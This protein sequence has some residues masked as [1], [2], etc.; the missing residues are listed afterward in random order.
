MKKL[1]WGLTG[2]ILLGAAGLH[3][4]DWRKEGSAEEQLANLVGL[5]PG[6]AHWMIEMGER[7]KNLYWAARQQKWEFAAYQ[8]EEIEKLVET[9]ILA[10]PGRAESAGIFLGNTF[11]A[12]HE[13]VA[14]QQWEQFETAFRRLN[15]ECMACHTRE[16][17]GFVQIPPEPATASSPVLNLK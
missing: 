17:H 13:A 7:Y 16:D 8:A 10:R 11:P 5:V 2:M 14:S 6:A 1:T 3:A 4:A 15:A 9:L 12:L